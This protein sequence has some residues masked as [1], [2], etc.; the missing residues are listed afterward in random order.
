MYWIR[1][2][3]ASLATAFCLLLLAPAGFA[4]TLSPSESSLLRAVNATRLA[5]GLR[6]LHCDA[7]LTRAA[8]A[9]STEMLQGEAFSHGDFRGRM[10][11]FHVRG[12]FLGENL[13]WGSGSY[14]AASTVIAEWLQSPEHR[15]NLLR[16]SLTRVG[17]GTSRGSFL[18]RNGA[19]VVTADFAGS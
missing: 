17:I 10:L 12:P 1:Q 14:A 11:A 13:A 15:A 18:G 5:Y 19:L 6:S 8:R 9:H 16:P 7:T 3:L 2:V 4:A